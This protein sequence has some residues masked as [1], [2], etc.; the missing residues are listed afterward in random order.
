VATVRISVDSGTNETYF[1]V[2]RNP[3]SDSVW[4]SI[5]RYAS[6]GGDF[7][8]KYIVFGMNS[9][10]EEIDCFAR[11]AQSAGVTKVCI[12]VEAHSAHSPSG[13]MRITLRELVAAS[14]I[15]NLMKAGNVEAYFES[16]WLPDHIDK[17]EQIGNFQ[18][19]LSR[20]ISPERE[21][22]VNPTLRL[23]RRI[24]RLLRDLGIRHPRSL[25]RKRL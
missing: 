20:I 8:L 19:N 21:K 23:L 17:I 9:D 14:L 16:I 1:K 3:H 11:R 15:H 7:I 10:I 24:R 25:L 12:S 6:T 2:K 5:R 4:E 18:S 22:E 13:D